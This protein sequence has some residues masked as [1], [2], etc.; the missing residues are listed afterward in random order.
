MSAPQASRDAPAKTAGTAPPTLRHRLEYVL[1]VALLGIAMRLPY[2]RRVRLS[3]WIAQHVLASV[4]G[5]KKRIRRNLAHVFP[6][7]PRA[8]VERLCGAVS[9][10]IGR[11]FIELLSGK[12]FAR[13][14]SAMPIEGPG[15]AALEAADAQHRPVVLVTGHLGNFDVARA[16]LIARGFRVAGLYAPMRN[17]LVNRRYVAAIESI[18]TPLFARGREGLAGMV[19]FLRGGGML[20]VVA[21]QYMQHG[22]PLDFLGKPALTALSA[23]ELALKYDA[24]LVPVY[25]I[26]QPDGLSFKVLL[27]APLPHSDALSMTQALNDSLGA[28]VRQHM[29][30]WFWVHRRW[31]KD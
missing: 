8:E 13:I 4:S 17:A 11:A 24:L 6:D 21:D 25:A 2:R 31:F 7:M 19:R 23:A 15:L 10:N 26:R 28:Q 5:V 29:E 3:G 18:G 22:V 14:A 16:A 27:E 20:G 9:N 1:V 12:E 30:Q